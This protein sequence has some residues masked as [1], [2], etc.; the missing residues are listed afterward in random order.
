MRHIL[1]MIVIFKARRKARATVSVLLMSSAVVVVMVVA[2]AIAKVSVA[3]AASDRGLVELY[4]VVDAACE[5]AEGQ[6]SGIAAALTCTQGTREFGRIKV[7]Y[8]DAWDK[9][10]RARAGDLE[11]VIEFCLSN[12]L[13]ARVARERLG[14]EPIRADGSVPDV[15][16]RPVAVR[17]LRVGV[18]LVRLRYGSGQDTEKTIN[19]GMVRA[20]GAQQ[21]ELLRARRDGG[22]SQSIALRD[23]EQAWVLIVNDKR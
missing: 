23:I 12:A 21:L 6:R 2:V 9:A 7:K 14:H 18:D 11:K 15:Y 22:G 20:L 17:E 4:G 19:T 1:T 3:V 8:R 13:S 16:W 5:C 10:A